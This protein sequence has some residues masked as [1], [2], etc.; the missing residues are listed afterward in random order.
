MKAIVLNKYGQSDVLQLQEVEKPI[1]KDD[2]V[3]VKVHA[4]SVNDWDWCLMRGTPFYIRLLCGLLKPKIQIPGAEIAGRVEVVGGNVTKFQLGDA[5]YGDISESGFGGFAEYVCVPENALAMKPDNMT[6]VE[7]AAIPHAAMLAVQ[8]LRDQG[9]IQPGQKLLINGAGGGVGTLGVQIAKSMG[10][11]DITGVDSS[12]KLDMMHS[13]GFVQTIDYTQEDF[14]QNKQCYD[15]ILDTKTNRSIFK[16]MRVLKSQGAY[17]TVGGSTDKLFQA[18]FLGPII[19]MF[20]KKSI[21]IV[22]LKPNKDLDYI[23]ELFSTGKVK[24]VIDGSYKLS[25]VPEAIQYFGEG[26]HKGKV[27]ITL[28]KNNET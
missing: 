10:V 15:L 22:N 8:G 3:L 16:Y 2:E 21:R 24:P 4:T 9:Q 25:E 19:R 5:V 27:V 12:S 17:V 26:K 28:D 18:L 11:F 6:F 1:P 13:I 14:T 7:A 23:N 20:S